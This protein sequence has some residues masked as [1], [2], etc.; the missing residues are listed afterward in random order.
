VGP[1]TVVGLGLRAVGFLGALQV[2]VTVVILTA[3][4]N[5]EKPG[6]QD[7][8][9]ARYCVQACSC[10]YVCGRDAHAYTHRVTILAVRNHENLQCSR[11]IVVSFLR[12]CGIWQEKSFLVALF[13]S[14]R[15]QIFMIKYLA[16]FF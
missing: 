9:G 16:H 10:R 1:P 12:H 11:I 3:E 15:V 6:G 7:M 8:L 5:R 13:K 14:T 4:Q 2:Q